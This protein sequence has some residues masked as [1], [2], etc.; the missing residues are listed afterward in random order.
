MILTEIALCAVI[1]GLTPVHQTNSS[2][3]H[4]STRPLG[5]LVESEHHLTSEE[6]VLPTDSEFQMQWYCNNTG[7]LIQGVVGIPGAD[8]HVFLAW[9]LL[10][11]DQLVDSDDSDDSGPIVAVIDAGVS[12]SHPDLQGQ[13]LPGLNLSGGPVDVTDDAFNSHGTSVAG[14]IAAN[15]DND[16]GIA[17]IA[18]RSRIMP[19]KIFNPLGFGS[20][21][22]AAEGLRF[23]VDHGADIVV[24]SFGF[25]HE[26]DE[27]RQA[28]LE[29]EA[30]GVL[31]V[32]STG[33]IASLPVPYP[34]AWPEVIA[35]GATD[36]FDERAVFSG[37]G[38]EIDLVAPG[39]NILTTTDSPVLIDG[40]DYET[41]TSFAAPVVAGVAALVRTAHPD[42]PADTLREIL[43]TTATDLADPGWDAETGHG[44]ID[45]FA[46]VALAIT[47]RDC[48]ADVNQD[49]VLNALDF[50]EWLDAFNQ[51]DPRADQNDDGTVNPTDF[52]AWLINF[53]SGCEYG[54]PID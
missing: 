3:T 45:A 17:G 39:V 19:I 2:V 34:A 26:S 33:N 20:P 11:P 18:P 53:T 44:R 47:I 42:L 40:Y 27:F 43:L 36:Q 29:A 6:L 16:T 50:S 28:V 31:M 12:E 7:Q 35:V 5:P 46:A 32:A 49:G 48:E 23:A 38:D 13:L 22:W 8:A 52:G 9:Q 25:E 14:I 4:R 1:S 15:W 24:M 30:A 10:G 54:T 37:G 41:G 21:E 51:G